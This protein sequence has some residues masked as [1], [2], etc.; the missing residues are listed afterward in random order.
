[1][2]YTKQ[3]RQ[4]CDAYFQPDNHIEGK[5]WRAFPEDD[6]DAAFA[7]AKRELEVWLNRALADPSSGARYRDDY[8]HYEQALWILKNTPRQAMDGTEQA[9]AIPTG[10]QKG[11]LDLYSVGIAPRAQHFL[12]LNRIKMVRG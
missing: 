9:K 2:A 12:A 1:M 4:D 3:R 5:A 8:A 11:V 6:K 10:K 7:Q